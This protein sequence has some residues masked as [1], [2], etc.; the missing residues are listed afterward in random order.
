MIATFHDLIAKM[1]SFFSERKLAPYDKI[2]A[3]NRYYIDFFAKN[4]VFT[5]RVMEMRNHIPPIESAARSSTA[6]MR[7]ASH[8]ASPAMSGSGLSPSPRSIRALA[9]A[10][11]VD[12][13][14]REAFVIGSPALPTAPQFLDRLALELT[15]IWYRPLY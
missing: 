15:E 5:E 3:T 7:A 13:V 12:D 4:A 2:C 1:P 10:G 14:L 6:N 9:L 11:M 8:A